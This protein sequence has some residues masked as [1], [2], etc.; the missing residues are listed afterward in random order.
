VLGGRHPS[1]IKPT[2]ISLAQFSKNLLSQSACATVTREGVDLESIGQKQFAAVVV[3][4]MSN[5]IQKAGKKV[6]DRRRP[7]KTE[8]SVSGPSD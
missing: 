1:N 7:S 8:P 3:A 6:V 2:L 5:L 4:A